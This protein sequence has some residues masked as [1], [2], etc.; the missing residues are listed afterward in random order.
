MIKSAGPATIDEITGQ[1]GTDRSAL[2]PLLQA[3]QEEYGF[4][5]IDVLDELSQ[6]I[7]TS[8]NEI[9]GVATF[10]S[11]FRFHPPGKHRIQ[12][13]QGTACHVRGAV[14]VINKLQDE[15]GIRSGETTPDG[16]FDL[17]RVACLGCCALAP[18]IAVDGKVHG[19]MNSKKI[20]S[21]LLRYKK[22]IKG[23]PK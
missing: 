11:M 8:A 10:Y 23:N 18:V 12:G 3:V 19:A 16:S 15:L 6:E 4:L 5:P 7:G 1:I 20:K 21:L 2:I 14:G 13:C 9:Y 22:E 17:E